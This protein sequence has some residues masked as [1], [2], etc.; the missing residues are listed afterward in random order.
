MSRSYSRSCNCVCYFSTPPLPFVYLPQLLV[1]EFHCQLAPPSLFVQICEL[2]LKA[3]SIMKGGIEARFC[4]QVCTTV[5]GQHICTDSTC[6][7]AHLLCKGSRDD[8]GY[9]MCMCR[10]SACASAHNCAGIVGSVVR[11]IPSA[12]HAVYH[13][14]WHAVHH[15]SWHAVH[16]PSWHAAASRCAAAMVCGAAASRLVCRTIIDDLHCQHAACRT[17]W[18]LSLEHAQIICRTRMGRSPFETYSTVTLTP[19][20]CMHVQC[21][22]LHELEAFDGFKRSCRAMLMRRTARR[23]SKQQQQL[24]Q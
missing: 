12:R 7:G 1:V 11:S 20:H 6:A 15:P 13:P 21:G 22:C 14:S 18:G 9:S 5:Q 8:Q 19:V 24:Q 3:A 4:Q 17:M 23:S 2:H 16:H 10:G